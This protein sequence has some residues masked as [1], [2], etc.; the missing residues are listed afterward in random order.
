M[1]PQVEL[2]QAF[3]RHEVHALDQLAQLGAQILARVALQ[4]LL[5]IFGQ[6]LIGLGHARVQLHGLGRSFRQQGVQLLPACFQWRGSHL[7][8]VQVDHALHEHD[9]GPL[10]LPTDLERLI[11]HERPMTLAVAAD[12]RFIRRH[13]A[14]GGCTRTTT[15]NKTGR[16][17]LSGG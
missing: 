1:N 17:N 5:Q 2:A 15:Q 13:A 7:Q 10:Q 4:G 12:G 8:R 16:L 11:L 3:Q 6:S 9:L 14:D